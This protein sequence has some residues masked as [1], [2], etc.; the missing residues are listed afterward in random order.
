MSSID[1]SIVR[2][3]FEQN[4]FL[5]RQ[6][7]KYQ[8]Q[9]RKKTADEEIDLLVYNPA[10]RSGE[11]RPDFFLSASELRY[12]HRAMVVIKPWH[13]W[14]FTPGMLRSSTQIF[15]FLEQNVLKV[16]TRL[17][18]PGEEEI[19]Q[20]GLIKILVLPSLP[21][22]KS[23]RSQSID[24][25]REKGVDGIISFRSMLIELVSRVEVNLNYQKSEI[26]QII[27]VLKNYDIIRDP[28][29]ELFSRGKE[30]FKRKKEK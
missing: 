3:Y 16:A 17:L 25:L 2:E 22:Q 11:R 28:Q 26:L 19:E 15:R 14:R 10:F 29:M 5:V 20:D 23:F 4:G 7:R 13:T 21:T 6:L 18:T 24:L 30:T 27:R 8:V 9:S 1:E 12:I